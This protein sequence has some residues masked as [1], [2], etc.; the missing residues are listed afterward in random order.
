MTLE[1]FF[2]VNPT[3]ALALSGGVDSSALAWAAG[4]Y[5][6]D[7][8]AYAVRSAFQPVF[9]LED[10]KR[11]AAFAGLPLTVL[12]VDV[13]SHEEIA[14]NPESRC[15]F[16][17][18]LLFETIH[19]RAKADGYALLIDGTNASDSATDRPGLRALR[20]LSV[21][22][23]LRE[24]GLAKADVRALARGAGLFNWDKPSY[25]CLATRVPAGTPITPEA[26]Q[27]AERGEAA[28]SALGFRDFRLRV[29]GDLALLQL[30]AEQFELALSRREEL[31]S[32]LSPLFSDIA[33]DLKPRKRAE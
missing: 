30:Q 11:A 27:K 1:E 32:A 24:C 14:E 22:S 19:T 28:I 2:R 5:G 6:R 21:R 4:K 15:Y 23:P 29:R 16:C 13:L 20:E 7:Y 33:V 18:R 9:E 17:K 10:T 12:D 3:G 8:R 25:A 26:L 31:Q